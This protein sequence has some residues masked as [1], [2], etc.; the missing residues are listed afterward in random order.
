MNIRGRFFLLDKA[1][2]MQICGRCLNICD[3]WNL[4][5]CDGSC[6]A[7]AVLFPPTEG[8]DVT[9]VPLKRERTFTFQSDQD[10][11]N[12]Q[13]KSRQTF[14]DFIFY[15]LLKYCNNLFRERHVHLSVFSCLGIWRVFFIRNQYYQIF[16]FFQICS[17]SFLLFCWTVIIFNMQI[18]FD[19]L[20]MW[21]SY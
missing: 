4:W 13:F 15:T 9:D 11:A 1:F 20:C 17:E 10:H 7:N 18:I 2:W 8:N 16:L 21:L 19:Y 6:H 3:A 5:F 12:L 14:K